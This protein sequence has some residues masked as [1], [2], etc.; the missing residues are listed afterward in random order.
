MKLLL[1]IACVSLLASFSPVGLPSPVTLR[2]GLCG[3][4]AVPPTFAGE[5][6]AATFVLD[7]GAK[8]LSY[9]IAYT[10]LIGGFETEAHIHGPA[11]SGANGP[12]LHLLPLGSLKVGTWSYPPSLEDSILAGKTYVDVH[13]L[14]FPSGEFRGQI[15]RAN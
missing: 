13:S 7:P 6:G 9:R 4:Q 2:A 11:S 8:T 1:A 15:L 10:R 14:M 5:T 3:C 12:I